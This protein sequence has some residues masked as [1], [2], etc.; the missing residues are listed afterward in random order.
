[1]YMYIYIYIYIY[2]RGGS[3]AGYPVFLLFLLFFSKFFCFS[4]VLFMFVLCVRLVYLSFCIYN[5]T[6]HIKTTK[7]HKQLREKNKHKNIKQKHEYIISQ[8]EPARYL[9]LAGSRAGYPVFLF[10]FLFFFRNFSVDFMFCLCFR[11]V[12]LSFC[13]NTTQY[14]TLNTNKH[15]MGLFMTCVKCSK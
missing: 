1:M 7:Q 15:E 14:T 2:I 11:L 10:L 5:R 3:W 8:L 12:Y 4:S 9:F 6:T 13:L